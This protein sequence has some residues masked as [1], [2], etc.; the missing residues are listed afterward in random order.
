M[1]V[2][3]AIIGVL[4]FILMQKN[5]KVEDLYDDLLDT[6]AKL[7]L[8]EATKNVEKKR[9]AYEKSVEEYLKIHVEQNAHNLIVVIEP[10]SGTS[11]EPRAPGLPKSTDKLH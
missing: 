6:K 7:K 8:S 3:T 4:S 1:T 11:T 9:E 2:A 5:R 10:D